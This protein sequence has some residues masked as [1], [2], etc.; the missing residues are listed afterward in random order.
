MIPKDIK[1]A[2]DFAVWIRELSDH[3]DYSDGYVLDC[4]LELCD[5]FINEE[6]KK[7]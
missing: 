6:N 5:I 7:D 3:N 1:T 2:K 4:I